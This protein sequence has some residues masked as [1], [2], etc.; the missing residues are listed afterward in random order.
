[1]TTEYVAK[2]FRDKYKTSCIPVTAEKTPLIKWS[3]YRDKLP[4][5]EVS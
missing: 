3:K 4:T 1:M 2:L 5:N